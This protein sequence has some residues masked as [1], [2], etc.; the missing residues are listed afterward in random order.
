MTRKRLASSLGVTCKV[1]GYWERGVTRPPFD[2]L[3]GVE[4]LLAVTTAELIS[5]GEKE[6][7]DRL[8]VKEARRLFEGRE[9]MSDE[10]IVVTEPVV[11]PLVGSEDPD[12]KSE[13]VQDE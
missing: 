2:K 5:V 10:T 7:P 6:M 11:D 4:R 12:L 8:R 3:R 13:R 9:T 1:L